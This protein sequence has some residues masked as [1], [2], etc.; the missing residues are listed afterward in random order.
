MDI[1]KTAVDRFVE[2]IKLDEDTECWIWTSN[3]TAG[4]YGQ[5]HFQGRPQAAHRLAYEWMVGP[6][7]EGLHLDHLCR[8]RFCVNPAHLEPV[9]PAVNTQRGGNAIKTHCPKGHAYDERN[10]IWTTSK[11]GRD[12]HCR[13]CKNDQE[14]AKRHGTA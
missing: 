10:T 6:I 5:F 8:V 9:T 7:P 1:G 2:K 11:K 13:T 3:R 14:R 12:R 4:G